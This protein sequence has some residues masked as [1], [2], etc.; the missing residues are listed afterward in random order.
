MMKQSDQV[1]HNLLYR[2][3]CISKFPNIDLDELR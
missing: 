2:N 1:K 3:L